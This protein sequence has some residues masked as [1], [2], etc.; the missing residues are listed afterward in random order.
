[1]P[2]G[3]SSD[4]LRALERE[5]DLL[6]ELQRLKLLADTERKEGS[7]EG[8]SGPRAAVVAVING[9][10]GSSLPVIQASD[11]TVGEVLGEGRIK[12]AYKGN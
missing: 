7:E 1:M 5:R 9:S 2:V 3:G 11:L 8:C 4:S 6:L 10:H 12:I